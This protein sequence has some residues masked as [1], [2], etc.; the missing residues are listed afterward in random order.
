MANQARFA[1]QGMLKPCGHQGDAKDPHDLC[2]GCQEQALGK[3][4]LC[5]HQSTCDKCSHLNDTDWK[6]IY[7]LRQRREKRRQRSQEA[8][9]L[10]VAK[11]LSDCSRSVTSD[12]KTTR[13]MPDTEHVVEKR[14]KVKQRDASKFDSFLSPPS[15]GSQAMSAKRDSRGEKRSHELSESGSDD[16]RRSERRFAKPRRKS[17]PLYDDRYVS[18]ARYMGPPPPPDYYRAM[19]PPAHYQ[20]YDDRRYMRYESRSPS[21]SRYRLTDA[22]RYERRSGEHRSRYDAERSRSRRPRSSDRRVASRS[23][24]RN[25]SRSKP[26]SSERRVASRSKSR[27][28]SRSKPRSRS[29][30]RSRPAEQSK[31]QKTTS[32]TSSPRDE[33]EVRM[34]SPPQSP[35]RTRPNVKYTKRKAQGEQTGALVSQESMQRAAPEKVG[36]LTGE[37]PRRTP[38]EP[39]L[40]GPRGDAGAACRNLD[41]EQDEGSD[42][43]PEASDAAEEPDFPFKD[44][45]RMIA[46]LSEAEIS[47]VKTKSQKRRL[48]LLSDDTS[49]EPADY[50]ALTTASG[51]VAGVEAWTEEFFEKDVAQPRGKPV[52]YKDSFRSKVLK[53]EFRTYK[54]GDNLLRLAALDKP[55]ETFS[56]LP[57][58]SKRHSLW[59]ADLLYLEEL[60]RGAL[61]VI[62]FKELVNQAMNK[63]LVGA[64]TD[65]DRLHRCSK[66]ANKELLRVC[67]CLLGMVTQLRRDDII[68]RIQD[69]T[70]AQRARLRHSE[71]VTASDLFPPKLLQEIDQEYQTALTNKAVQNSLRQSGR[72]ASSRGSSSQRGRDRSNSSRQQQQSGQKAD[73]GTQHGRPAK[74][75]N[76]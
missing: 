47:D 39:K 65:A 43:E 45:I 57:T 40:V 48:T 41:F 8:K 37:D 13:D 28:R 24:S 52:R 10:R 35:V 72:A 31:R 6:L 51:V 74:G 22:S 71:L 25:R 5:T 12:P 53:P 60:A 23:K 59:D 21:N 62:S 29:R 50:A 68:S 26:R 36:Q 76:R 17:S 38:K 16:E 18:S 56:W 14:N 32:R 42:A 1:L 27:N 34:V 67:A 44:V 70:T 64:S 7:T 4:G 9:T 54:E 2:H 49:E 75:Q 20:P 11:V 46:R 66:E 73:S 15:G 55:K 3:E 58:A 30:S 19:P 69:V 61:R 63:V 33:D